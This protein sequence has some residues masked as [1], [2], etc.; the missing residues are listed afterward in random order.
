MEV[1]QGLILNEGA[2]IWSKKVIEQN[3]LKHNG[4]FELWTSDPL[5]QLPTELMELTTLKGV[6]CY[7]Y[8]KRV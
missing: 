4:F 3:I 8:G 2:S 6:S 7:I 1:G 5:L